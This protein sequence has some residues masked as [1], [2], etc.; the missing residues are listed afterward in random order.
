MLKHALI[1]D[2]GLRGWFEIS[3][4]VTEVDSENSGVREHRRVPSPR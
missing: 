3:V 1:C 2:P 4:G